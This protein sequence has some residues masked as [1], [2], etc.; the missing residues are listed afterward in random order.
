MKVKTKS[1]QS[2]HPNG[3]IL[4]ITGIFLLMFGGLILLSPLTSGEVVV[5]IVAAV[6][7]VTGVLRLAYAVKTV[8]RIEKIGSFALGTAIIGLAVLVWLSPEL[9]SAVL[10][11]LLAVFFLVHGLWKISA[12][13]HYRQ[14]AVWGWILLSGIFSLLFAWLMWQQWPLSGAW[15]IGI[16]VGL[17][18]LLTGI[19]SIMLARALKRFSKMR[20]LDTISL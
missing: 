13:F 17:D 12:A 15:A 5:Q 6:L 14:F 20:A 1:E 9:G 8:R 16:L 11:A 18:L 4:M 7:F 2:L 3:N 19:V 10:T